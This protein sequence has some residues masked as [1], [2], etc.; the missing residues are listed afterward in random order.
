MQAAGG[1]DVDHQTTSGRLR[2]G[3]FVDDVDVRVAWQLGGLDGF[4]FV[5]VCE[6]EEFTD[7][8]VLELGIPHELAEN[9]QLS[10]QYVRVVVDFGDW[11]ARHEVRRQLAAVKMLNVVRHV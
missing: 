7:D 2:R 8:S 10:K 1:S 6:S 5:E 9:V 4:G 11:G 3:P